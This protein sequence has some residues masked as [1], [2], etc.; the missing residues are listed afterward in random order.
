MWIKYYLVQ[1]VGKIV[2]KKQE[3]GY[4]RV[5]GYIFGYIR[6]PLGCSVKLRVNAGTLELHDLIDY[7]GYR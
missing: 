3:R 1:Q 7:S 5:V 4:A 6:N 2:Y